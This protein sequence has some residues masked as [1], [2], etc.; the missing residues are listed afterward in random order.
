MHYRLARLRRAVV[1][2]GP[3]SFVEVA[4]VAGVLSVLAAITFGRHVL[5]GG[6]YSDD[7]GNAAVFRFA[8]SP[9]FF[10]AVEEF[11][12]YLGSRPVL[13]VVLALPHPLFGDH[14]WAH[15]VL[16]LMLGV[17]SCL[18]CYLFLR[19]IPMARIHAG[20]IA[21]LALVFPWAD[22]IRL[23]PTASLNTVALDFAFLGAFI[24]LVGI[25]REGRRSTVALA[26]SAA[27]YALSVLTYEV[28][29]IALLL[30][31][32]LYLLNAPR[33]KALRWWA[34]HAAVVG[35]ALVYTALTTEKP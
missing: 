22:A 18:C 9:R 11:A 2:T 4:V 10:N 31:G 8:E 3:V 27:L 21:C 1:A 25:R 35:A 14:L 26:G 34:V 32:A 29:G 28:A 20:A 5:D 33:S 19:A 17:V 30:V 16:S 15:H 6:F 7:W 13:A 12:G 23:W 24:A